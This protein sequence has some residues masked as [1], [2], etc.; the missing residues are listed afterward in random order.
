MMTLTAKA[1]LFIERMAPN[2]ALII[3]ARWGTNPP[4]PVADLKRQTGMTK[5][6]IH[7]FEKRA[8]RRLQPELG[9]TVERLLD[10]VMGLDRHRSLT[11]DAI[12]S[13]ELHELVPE[14]GEH[15]RIARRAVER[16]TRLVH[17]HGM[18]IAEAHA[19]LAKN[20]PKL[21]RR[22]ADSTGVITDSDALW[23][24]LPDNSWREHWHPWFTDAAGMSLLNG[25]WVVKQ[26][27]RAKVKT[28]LMGS[29]NP[30]T[31]EEIAERSGL[32]VKRAHSALHE[33]TTYARTDQRHWT[34][35]DRVTEP[36]TTTAKLIEDEIRRSGG[37]AALTELVRL[38]RE[39][40]RV[41]ATTVT[42]TCRNLMFEHRGGKVK[43][44]DRATITGGRLTDAMH[45][46]DGRKRPY[47]TFPVTDRHL[48]GYSITFMPTAIAK[49]LGCRPG[50]RSTATVHHG[51]NAHEASISWTL[52][53]NKSATIGRLR[54]GLRTIGAKPGQRVRIAINDDRSLEL[55]INNPKDGVETESGRT[56]RKNPRHRRTKTRTTARA[57]QHVLR[58]NTRPEEQ[59]MTPRP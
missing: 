32:P 44:R 47:W 46:L 12:F 14:D 35:A 43:L 37:E 42:T 20:L 45:G 41:K 56:V 59:R 26:T 40:W 53:N 4:T 15:A 17:M 5:Q 8:P 34:L 57:A 22:Y 48:N 39:K 33:A 7:Q 38:L 21:A 24:A 6:G 16:E 19:K 49:T 51:G 30:L 31:V 36:Y 13:Q 28:T 18:R 10:R 27:A 2:N 25:F 54:T 11:T 52:T 55:S 58:R 1:R 3:R 50:E 23:A 9:E 29:R